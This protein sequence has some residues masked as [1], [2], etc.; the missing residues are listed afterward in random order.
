M[1]TLPPLLSVAASLAK[2]GLEVI[3]PQFLL[4]ALAMAVHVTPLSLD[5]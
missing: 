3:P 1:Y 4:P 2:S 5:M